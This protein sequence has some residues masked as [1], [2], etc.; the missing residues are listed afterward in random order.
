MRKMA[1]AFKDGKFTSESFITGQ[2]L[3]REP[4]MSIKLLKISKN[5]RGKHLPA[6]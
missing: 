3:I 2:A 5:K 4:S 1:M 6:I